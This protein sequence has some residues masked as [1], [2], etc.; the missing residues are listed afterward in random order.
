MLRDLANA[1]KMNEV[2]TEILL[3]ILSILISTFVLRFAWNQS[4][5]KH[6]S[7]LKPIKTF[8]DAFIL[9]LALSV[10]RGI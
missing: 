1:K 10:V 3:F 2:I 8:Q 7:T 5:V 6:V 4:L 9:S